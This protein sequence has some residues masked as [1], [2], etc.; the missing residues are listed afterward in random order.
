MNRQLRELQDLRGRLEDPP[1]EVL[2]AFDVI[3]AYLVDPGTSC[4]CN[5]GCDRVNGLMPVPGG[6]GAVRCLN[7]RTGW[8]KPW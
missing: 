3:E 7:C 5:C 8:H 6:R 1:A 4:C 2:R